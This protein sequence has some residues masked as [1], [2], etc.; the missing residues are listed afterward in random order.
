M[1]STTRG[2][3]PGYGEKWPSAKIAFERGL[4]GAFVTQLGEVS[5][6][7]RQMEPAA[8]AFRK[9]YELAPNL[10]ATNL[11]LGR[12]LQLN[13]NHAAAEKH[14]LAATNA[15]PNRP[16]GWMALAVIH[17][18][19]DEIPEALQ[20]L[21]RAEKADPKQGLAETRLAKLYLQ[22]KDLLGALRW[23]Q[24]AHDRNPDDTSVRLALGEVQLRLNL[25][26]PAKEQFEVV[27]AREENLTAL[28]FLAHMEESDGKYGQ[29]EAYY[30]RALKL[31]RTNVIANNNLAMLLMQLDRSPQEA[32]TL[33]KTAFEALPNSAAISGTYGCVLLWAGQRDAAR[34]FLARAVR[35][36]P[37]DPWVR[38]AYGKLLHLELKAEQSRVHLEG[39]LILDRD[40]PRKSEIL[41]LLKQ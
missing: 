2:V 16:E 3:T 30:R 22:L 4:I 21:R 9:A 29:A 11:S 35:Q 1:C 41:Q 7:Q 40:F 5:V 27:V 19:K 6:R 36:T 26:E 10:F 14:Y 15:S 12:F 18:R 39:C 31:D 24:A 8:V 13:G 38:Y 32:L 28:I 34:K 33:V 25:R 20:M 17:V 23:Y 37:L